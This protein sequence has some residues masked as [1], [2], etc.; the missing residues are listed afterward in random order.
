MTTK[1]FAQERTSTTRK[2]HSRS[3][4]LVLG[5]LIGA[6]AITAATVGMAGQ[7]FALPGQSDTGSTTANVAVGSAI[8]LTVNTPSFVLSGLAGATVTDLNAVSLT[9][10]T[11][12]LAG[13]AVTVEAAADVLAP[14]AT[15][16]TDSIPIGALSV[17]ENG[18]G[19]YTPLSSTIATTVHTQAFR[20]APGGDALSNDYQVVIPDVNEDTY[21]ATLNY[22]AT[23]L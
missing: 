5:G 10:D 4:R 11:N 20:A 12:N 22:V 3:R 6:T 23:T 14:T 7:A 8:T 1:L 9:V 17:E 15:G 16:N 2:S 13:Y 21:T 19:P 18:A